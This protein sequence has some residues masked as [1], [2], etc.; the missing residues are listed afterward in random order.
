LATTTYETIRTDEIA[1]IAALTPGKLSSV[2][3]RLHRNEEPLRDWAELN[4]QACFRVFTVQNLFDDEP[5]EVI[6]QQRFIKG[7]QEVVVAYPRDY[8]YGNQNILDMHDIMDQDKNQIDVSVGEA[9][10]ASL[11][12]VSNLLQRS[13]VELGDKVCFAVLVYRHHYW[14]SDV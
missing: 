8:R 11:A 3:Y 9:G 5:P 7:L 2:R 10:F 12:N 13:T 14:R 1:A 6:N 4:P